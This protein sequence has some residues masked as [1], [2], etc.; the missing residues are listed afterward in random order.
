MSDAPLDVLVLSRVTDRHLEQIR[1][2]DPR[3][4]VTATAD[5]AR[6]NGMAKDAEVIVGW[7]IPGSV[8]ERAP[9]LKWIH[10]TAAG[11]DTLLFP[12]VMDGRVRLTSSV[13]IHTTVLPEHVMAVVLAFARRLHVAV[14]NQMARRWDRASTMGEELEGKVL[15]ILGLGAI[16]RALAPR[17][18]VFGMRVIGTKRTPEPIPHVE[19]VLTPEHTDEVLCT[20]DFLV[21]LLPLTPQTRGL[22]DARALRL[23]KSSAV[24]INVGRGPIVQEAALMDA[25]RAGVIAGAGLD[26]FDH[27]PLPSDSPFYQMENVII[28]PHVSGASPTY[29]DR[30]IPLFCE[31]LRRYLTGAPLLNVVDPAR[32]Y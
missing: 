26:V 9:R 3:V 5:R 25:L 30:A 11:V 21:I 2:V 17:A 20:A 31:N 10:A 15:G 24:L 18:A 19:R 32:G 28:T 14:R 6:A 29:L 23:M 12:A 8:I 7:L 13:G 27:E 1:A 4:R 16:G 22:I